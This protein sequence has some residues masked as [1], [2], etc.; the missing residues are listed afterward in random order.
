[1]HHLMRKGQTKFPSG[2]ISDCMDHT[3]MILLLILNSCFIHIIFMVLPK[4]IDGNDANKECPR[5]LVYFCI[6]SIL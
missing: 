6:F 5:R 1:M 4:F 2:M 3:G